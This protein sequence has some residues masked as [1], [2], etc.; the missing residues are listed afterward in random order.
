ME[1][2][3]HI[4]G[5]ILW[6]YSLKFRP[7]IGLIYDGRSSGSDSMEVC[8][9]TIFLRPYKLWGYSL[10]F[11]PEKYRPDN[12]VGTSGLGS[13]NGHWCRANVKMGKLVFWRD[14]FVHETIRRFPV[15]MGVPPNHP[16]HYTFPVL[17]P[18][19]T[20]GIL[21]LNGSNSL[22]FCQTTSQV[23]WKTTLQSIPDMH[24]T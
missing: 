8:K 10:K 2:L 23:T 21:H 20:L 3:Y 15:K 11:R 9:R 18:T 17:K 16:S 6:G 1:V 24:H 12:M 13:W 5:H 14:H 19:L 7:Y 4:F 22:K